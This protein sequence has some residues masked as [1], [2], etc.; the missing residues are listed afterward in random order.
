M[1]NVSWNLVVG[2]DVQEWSEIAA[3]DWESVLAHSLAVL[4]LISL[5]HVAVLERVLADGLAAGDGAD[6]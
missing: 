4:S 1:L 2:V 3:L 6:W 5:V